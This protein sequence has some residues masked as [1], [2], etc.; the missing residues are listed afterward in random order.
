MH[1]HMYSG[2]DLGPSGGL[3]MATTL[4]RLTALQNV[5]LK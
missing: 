3:A 2:N 1:L 4:S 5:N